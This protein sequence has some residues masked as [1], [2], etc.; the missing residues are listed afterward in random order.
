VVGDLLPYYRRLRRHFGPQGW[1]PARNRLEVVVGTIL[2]QNTAW[3]NVEAALEQLRRAHRLSLPGL[4]A[5]SAADLGQLIRSAGFWRQ[6]A[7]TVQGLVAWLDGQ[8]AGR[9]D[10]MVRLPTPVLR[11]QLLQLRG[12]G[13]ET[14]DSILLY[15]GGHATFVVDAYTRRVLLRHHLGPPPPAPSP[16]RASYIQVQSWIESRLPR[17][18]EIYNEFHAL[19]VAV[20]KSYCHRREPDCPNCPLRPLL[21]GDG[22]P[23]ARI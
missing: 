15:A 11:R 12:V 14:A 19:L 6:K 20:G 17:Q 8:H 21:P 10:R 1:W 23:A 9:L 13:P 7:R 16:D 18:A 5:L 2:V 22:R 4:R 3:R